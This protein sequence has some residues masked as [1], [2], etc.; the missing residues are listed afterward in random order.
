MA[1]VSA[2]GQ[3]CH[4][5]E[6]D[7]QA[8]TAPQPARLRGLTAASQLAVKLLRRA[9]SRFEAHGLGVNSPCLSSLQPRWLKRN[10]DGQSRRDTSS[11]SRQGRARLA[12]LLACWRAEL[13]SALA[14]TPEEAAGIVEVCV[15]VR[16]RVRV[17]VCVRACVRACVRVRACVFMCFMF[18]YDGGT[19]RPKSSGP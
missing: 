3:W 17:G 7:L 6:A 14:G 10:L 11:V 1:T 13:P 15:C 2:C 5:A 16:A 12:V 19:P 9:T 4:D 18:V 8:G